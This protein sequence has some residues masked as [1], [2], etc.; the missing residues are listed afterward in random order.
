MGKNIFRTILV[1][2][3]LLF[4]TGHVAQDAGPKDRDVILATTTSTQ[5]S[6]LLD[7]LIPLFE[8]QT[9]Y[10]V[11]TIAV[12]T[13]QAL[14]MAAKGEADVVLVHAPSLENKYV[15]QGKLLN[16]RVV[17]YND[18]III[19]PSNDPAKIKSSKT[20]AAALKLIEQSHAPFVSRGDNSGTHNLEKSL[21]K[22]AG[23]TP[24]GA[25]Y[26]ESA[27]GMGATLN[28]ANDRSA[29]TISDR[30]TYLASLKG[31]TLSILVQGDRRLLNLY[32]VMEVNPTN[33]P[34]INTA[35][36]KAF[37]DFMVAP[38]T[39]SVIKNFDLKKF[40]QPLFVPVWR[41]LYPLD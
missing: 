28:I 14:A 29:Y 35:G 10:R 17:M 25:W 23:I 2:A 26:V 15:A 33:G 30:G 21:W 34:K 16:R 5:D 18:F 41:S 32:S 11:K 9:G 19:G 13:G 22:S 3:S 7:V 36:G 1:A 4:M 31:L 27:Q 40:G 37:A 39:Q 8:E 38:S 24:K 12:G 20:A 6:G